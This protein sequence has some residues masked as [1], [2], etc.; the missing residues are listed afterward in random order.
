MPPQR[1]KK[2]SV[3]QAAMAWF[4]LAVSALAADLDPQYVNEKVVLNAG[5]TTAKRYLDTDRCKAAVKAEFPEFQGS[6]ELYLRETF[7]SMIR[8][9]P[10]DKIEDGHRIKGLTNCDVS[11]NTIMVSVTSAMWEPEEYPQTLVHEYIHAL[12]C[13]GIFEDWGS[14]TRLF[15]AAA[16]E[17]NDPKAI[18]AR[19]YITKLENRA[20]RAGALC[21]GEEPPAFAKK[22][23]ETE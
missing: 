1:T 2:S 13:K 16:G 9:L 3:V 20:Y 11:P 5:L 15:V 23:K 18:A 4:L 8:I 22:K 7:E 6:D 14:Q 21:V 19:A 17:M 12:S 10:V